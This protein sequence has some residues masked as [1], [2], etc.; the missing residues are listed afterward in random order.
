MRNVVEGSEAAVVRLE[1]PW[2]Q[3][4]QSGT[5]RSLTKSQALV[6]FSG[7]QIEITFM[8]NKSWSA[9]V[10]VDELGQHNK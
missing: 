2:P 4:H 7:Q 10:S 8:T 6:S 5:Q 3:N 9:E 1:E